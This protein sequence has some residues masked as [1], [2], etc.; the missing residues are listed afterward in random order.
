MFIRECVP[1]DSVILWSWN[2]GRAWTQIP[3]P[4]QGQIYTCNTKAQPRK[5]TTEDGP[6]ST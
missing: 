6:D 2:Y 5:E 4:L 1:Q 3:S